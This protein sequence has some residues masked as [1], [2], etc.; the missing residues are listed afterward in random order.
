MGQGI[1]PSQREFDESVRRSNEQ[2]AAD[3]RR[4]SLIKTNTIPGNPRD[5]DLPMSPGGKR[6]PRL[7]LADSDLPDG[8]TRAASKSVKK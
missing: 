8:F 4:T 2:K 1:Y 6:D 7:P 5:I 3:E